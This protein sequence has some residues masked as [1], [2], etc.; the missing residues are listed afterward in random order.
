MDGSALALVTASGSLTYAQLACYAPG[1]FSRKYDDKAA[2]LA[3]QFLQNQELY[4]LTTSG[5]TG[6]PKPITLHLPQM[7]ASAALTA[8]WVLP[9]LKPQLLC[10]LDIGFVAGFMQ[11]FRAIAWQGTAWVVEPNNHFWPNFDHIVTQ[12]SF[13]FATIVPPQGQYAVVGGYDWFQKIDKVLLGGMALDSAL[14]KTLV[15]QYQNLYMGYG[16]T[17]TLGHVAIRPLGTEAYTPLTGVVIELSEDHKIKVS[18]EVTDDKWLETNDLGVLNPDGSF[19]VIGR[20][21]RVINSG[22]KKVSPEW[23]EN[24]LA[25]LVQPILGSTALFI[26]WLPSNKW[27][28]EVVLALEQEK[29]LSTEQLQTLLGSL[30]RLESH[31]RPKRILTLPQ[32]VRTPTGK[33]KAEETRKLLL[34]LSAEA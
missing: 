8:S 18:S 12:A 13:H 2:I 22:G 16:M 29:S 34:L 17:E 15:A 11:L 23:L 9:P 10:C 3:R 20:A 6:I 21:D 1:T 31:L 30:S 27:G 26:T 33:V 4:T 5:T 19:R 25:P 32:F 7:R 24:I 14:E 28:Q